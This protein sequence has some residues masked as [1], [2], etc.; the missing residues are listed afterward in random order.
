[1]SGALLHALAGDHPG[2]LD[3]DADMDA[4]MA[5]EAATVSAATTP[6]ASRAS[7][8]RKRK[9]P[10]ATPT[11][12]TLSGGRRATAGVKLATPTTPSAA[13]GPAPELATTSMAPAADGDAAAKPSPVRR[14]TDEP[15]P[16]ARRPSARSSGSGAGHVTSQHSER[17]TGASDLVKRPTMGC[18]LTRLPAR[19]FAWPSRRGGPAA[20]VGQRR[21]DDAQHTRRRAHARDRECAC[22]SLAGAVRGRA[23]RAL[24]RGGPPGVA[25]ASLFRVG[26]FRR[27]RARLTRG[28][29]V[30]SDPRCFDR[31][32][33]MQ[34]T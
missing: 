8:G 18:L 3:L 2:I 22:G 13:A 5:T 21:G 31:I 23:H 4:G 9:S 11:S 12:S 27:R 17:L 14:R 26:R 34:H 32:P 28:S 10:S 33:L 7:G 19:L 30:A 24:A 20:A 1:M 16:R 25:R 6:Q 15:M 29:T